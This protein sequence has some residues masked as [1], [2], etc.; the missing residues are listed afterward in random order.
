MDPVVV[1]DSMV[2]VGTGVSET[3][4]VALEME[5]ATLE[6]DMAFLVFPVLGGS[7]M[8]SGRMILKSRR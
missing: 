5:K 4:L 3:G 1:V 7:S 2:V 8:I 6:Q